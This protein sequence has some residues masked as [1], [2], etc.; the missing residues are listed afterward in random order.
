[1]EEEET[2]E[3]LCAVLIRLAVALANRALC[4]QHHYQTASVRSAERDLAALR[5][6]RPTSS[7]A[8]PATPSALLQCDKKLFTKRPYTILYELLLV[9]V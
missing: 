4:V 8:C 2:V 1:M 6:Y 9:T 3:G 5:Q 7:T